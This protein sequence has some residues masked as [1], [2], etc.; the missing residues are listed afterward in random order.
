[1]MK[2][3]EERSCAALFYAV[4]SSHAVAPFPNHVDICSPLATI[5]SFIVFIS[6]VIFTF[7]S[8]I[9][10]VLAVTPPMFFT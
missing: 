4:D 10:G 3:S 1:M 6:C 2:V 5:L 8:S 9:F 7:V